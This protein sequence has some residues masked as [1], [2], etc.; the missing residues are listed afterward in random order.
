MSCFWLIVIDFRLNLYRQNDCNQR[1]ESKFNYQVGPPTVELSLVGQRQRVVATGGDH[2]RLDTD[3]HLDGRRD[4][5]GWEIA[6]A[7]LAVAVAAETEQLPVH[8]Q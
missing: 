4:A 5:F 8:S 1:H 7:Q 2:D 3:G 6:Q